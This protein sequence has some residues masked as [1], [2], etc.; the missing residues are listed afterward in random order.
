VFEENR[1]HDELDP[2]RL[3]PEQRENV[4]AAFGRD[5]RMQLYDCGIRRRLA[6]MFGNYRD[7]SAPAVR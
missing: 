1:S 2:R 6:P 7:G 5:K 3:T 4:F